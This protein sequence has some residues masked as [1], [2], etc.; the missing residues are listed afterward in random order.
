[1]IDHRRN[2]T[3]ALA[4]GVL[5]KKQCRRS[6]TCVE[7]Q[8]LVQQPFRVA[9]WRHRRYPEMLKRSI[10]ERLIPNGYGPLVAQESYTRSGSK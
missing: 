5:P 1:V 9:Y 10:D 2:S 3:A 8:C 7:A 4:F 6:G